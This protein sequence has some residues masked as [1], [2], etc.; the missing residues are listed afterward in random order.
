M[1]DQQLELNSQE[2]GREAA[3]EHRKIPTLV[4][5]TD[6]FEQPDALVL[7]ADMPGVDER[8]VD[9]QIEKNV[10]SL[11]GTVQAQTYGEHRLKYH[12]FETGRFERKFTL[13]DEIDASKIEA[14]VKDGVLRIRLPKAEAAKPRKITVSRG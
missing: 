1:T 6:I 5:A 7:I 14:S 8:D 4:P 3:A 10:L 11:T 12:E 2:V 13:S 9:I